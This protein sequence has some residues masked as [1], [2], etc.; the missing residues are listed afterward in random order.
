VNKSTLVVA[1]P[2]ASEL[3]VSY[4]ILAVPF[5]DTSTACANVVAASVPAN[6]VKPIFFKF[7]IFTPFVV[8]VIT[9]SVFLANYALFAQINDN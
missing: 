8:F 3:L 4:S 7:V 9:N 5:T 6:A 2:V 1:A